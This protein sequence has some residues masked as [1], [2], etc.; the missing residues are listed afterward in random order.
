MLAITL[1]HAGHSH[2][3]DLALIALLSAT[4][5]LVVWVIVSAVRPQRTSSRPTPAEPVDRE[6]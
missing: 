1:S 2:G 3:P 6:P 5:V 4:V